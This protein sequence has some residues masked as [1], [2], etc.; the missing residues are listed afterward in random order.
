[1]DFK[2]HVEFDFALREAVAE[3]Q[4]ATG[5]EFPNLEKKIRTHGAVEAARI[6]LTEKDG[7]TTGFDILKKAGRLD[8]SVERIV[9]NHA[10]S[11]LF[12]DYELETAKKRLEG[13]K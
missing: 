9:L 11:G 1:M 12:F 8:L 13:K 10:E 6:M 5:F 3:A 4:K 2:K 7:K